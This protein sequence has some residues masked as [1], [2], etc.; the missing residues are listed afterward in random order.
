MGF[1]LATFN[2]LDVF[3]AIDPAR[4]ERIARIGALLR[5]HAPDVVALQEVG[6]ID[7]ARAIASAIGGGYDAVIGDADER[8]IACALLARHRIASSEILRARHL[9]FPRFHV[10]DP[11]PFAMRIP[12][13]RSI[14]DVVVDVA[15]FGA[16]RVLVV[17]FKSRRGKPMR[18]ESGNA[19]EPASTTEIAETEARAVAWRCAEALFVRRAV[20]ARLREDPNAM[21]CVCGDFNDVPDSLP[22]RI[23]AGAAGVDPSAP[24][25]DALAS[26]A[27]SIPLAER[28]SVDHDGEPA[29][30][31]HALLSRALAARVSRAFYERSSSPDPSVTSDHA[32]L[33]VR[34]A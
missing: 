10:E 11:E 20:D 31:D 26:C 4:R 33:V 16:V 3:D 6:T 29:A 18:D 27:D 14:P 13:R 30:I 12:L 8:G 23:V 22:L 9:P 28:V 25:A 5:P 19:I 32:P 1:V 15:G 17:H 2:V 21:L 24:R 7:A 34:F